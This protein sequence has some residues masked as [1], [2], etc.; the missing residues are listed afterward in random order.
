MRKAF[1][2]DLSWV[3]SAHQ[4]H[5]GLIDHIEAYK[6]FFEHCGV[7]KMRNC[8]IAY[9]TKLL[10]FLPNQDEERGII[11]DQWTAQSINLLVGKPIVALVKNSSPIGSYR[12]A[13]SNDHGRLST[14]LQHRPIPGSPSQNNDRGS[15]DALVFR[16]T[17]QRTVARIRQNAWL[18]G[19]PLKS[20][21]LASSLLNK[22]HSDPSNKNVSSRSGV[23]A[24][25]RLGL[26][27]TLIHPD[28]S[29]PIRSLFLPSTP[30][31]A[32]Q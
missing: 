9:Y 32:D 3:N 13:L 5:L 14:I 24:N 22:P 8:A 29:S 28:A 26:D 7:G 11:M 25:P 16:R 2:Q 4:L 23:G 15:G 31:I 27:R 10:F 12:V 1:S 20:G 18:A 19:K 17:G 6:Q 30:R 21:W